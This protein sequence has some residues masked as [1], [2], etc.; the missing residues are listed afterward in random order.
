MISTQVHHCRARRATIMVGVLATVWC[1]LVMDCSTITRRGRSRP[2]VSRSAPGAVESHLVSPRSWL[3][4]AD[5]VNS[6]PTMFGSSAA[7]EKQCGAAE[8]WM[9]PSYG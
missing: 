8:A 6:S 5:G 7:I 9:I 3:T 4:R 2:S 1:V